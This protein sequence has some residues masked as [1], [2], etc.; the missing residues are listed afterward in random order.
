MFQL[1][2]ALGRVGAHET[3]FSQRSSAHDVNINAVW[4][5]DDPDG[6]GHI[7]WARR[8]F[9]A[10]QPHAGN[11]VYVNFLGDEG[12]DRV[13]QA[14][15]GSYERLVALKRAYDPTNFFHLNQN[16]AP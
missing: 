16:I 2:G 12:S 4:T 7:G 9:D 8:F 6:E 5:E 14:Y 13:R 11:H 15:G 10:M 1:G 3:A